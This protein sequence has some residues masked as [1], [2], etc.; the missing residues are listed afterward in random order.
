[1]RELMPMT[2]RARCPLF[3]RSYTFK[4]LKSSVP[5]N[6]VN[7]FSFPYTYLL[8]LSGTEQFWGCLFVWLVGCLHAF[9]AAENGGWRTEALRSWC[10][11]G[12]PVWGK[13][14]VKIISAA[15][16]EKTYSASVQ[17]GSPQMTSALIEFRFHGYKWN[18]TVC[19]C[20]RVD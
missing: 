18:L 7:T 15:M 1:M 5:N 19:Q 4:C 16:Q 12:W 9:Q 2:R 8:F 20:V 3:K 10:S 6:T 11:V 13:Q 14:P 17:P